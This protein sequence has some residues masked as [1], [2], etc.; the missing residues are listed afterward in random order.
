MHASC[1]ATGLVF[2]AFRV[3]ASCE[4]GGPAS[5]GSCKHQAVLAPLAVHC[6]PAYPRCYPITQRAAHHPTS[7]HPLHSAT[8]APKC[9]LQ[10]L[11]QPCPTPLPLAQLRVSN[12]TGSPR[13]TGKAWLPPRS[14]ELTVGC[15]KIA[16]A[17]PSHMG[18]AAAS[19]QPCAPYRTASSGCHIGTT[20]PSAPFTYIV[21][22]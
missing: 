3:R 10:G 15:C 5:Y 1:D 16:L 8:Q 6:T 9:G 12:P 4:A 13:D 11:A 20:S 22:A 14:Y 21:V 17:C 19:P 18:T 7:H 2:H